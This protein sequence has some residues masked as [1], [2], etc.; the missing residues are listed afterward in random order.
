MSLF[1]KSEPLHVRL[2]REGGID[3]EGSEREP[4]RPAWDEP[5]IHGRQRARRWDTVLTVEAP[6]LAGDRVEFVALSATELVIVEGEGAVEPLAEGVER[7]LDPPYRAEGVRRD[8]D[9]WAV[10]A[11]KIEVV[12]LPN[13]EGE[14]IELSS[15][16]GERTLLVD[17]ASAFG[18]IPALEQPEHVVRARRIDGDAWEVE[19]SPL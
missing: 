19:S 4:T 7:S 17:G 10:G 2:A 15:H 8:G 6:D 13:I 18:S 11:R 14:E 9:L 1:R 3:L 12:R 16:E 5:G